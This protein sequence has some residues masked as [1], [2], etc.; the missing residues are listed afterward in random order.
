MLWVGTMQLMPLSAQLLNEF[1]DSRT[2]SADS[3]TNTTESQMSRNTPSPALSVASTHFGRIF[4]PSVSTPAPVAQ[5]AYPMLPF[6]P[7]TLSP[8]NVP[9]VPPRFTVVLGGEIRADKF[10]A[11]DRLIDMVRE[12][13]CSLM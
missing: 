6:N 11:L 13:Q 2:A 9:V 12:T 3:A 8:R 10:R 1:E 7:N 5:T 4:S